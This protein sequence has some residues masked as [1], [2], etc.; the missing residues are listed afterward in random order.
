MINYTQEISTLDIDNSNPTIPNLI[1][2]VHIILTA[3]DDT[4]NISSSVGVYIRLEPGQSFIPFDQ[5][6]KE[7]VESWVANSATV[8]NAKP[9]LVRQIEEKRAD[10]AIKL[11]NPP[12]VI[13]TTSV[14][15]NVSV[16]STNIVSVSNPATTTSEIVPVTTL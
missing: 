13:P 12:W 8:E 3:T 9:I 14:P 2:G 1:V 10:T 5:L 6:T 7:I 11:V 16:E 15:L 4:D